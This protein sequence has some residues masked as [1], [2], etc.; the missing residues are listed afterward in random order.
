MPRDKDYYAVL[1]VSQSSTPEQIKDAYRAMVKQHHPDAAIGGAPD[2]EKFRDVMEAFSVLS[3][4]E[5]RTNY[6][7]LRKKQPQHFEAQTEAAFNKDHRPDLRDAAG[8]TPQAAPTPGSY[9]E[10]RL[11]ELKAQRE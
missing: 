1:G 4:R 10:E 8:N 9:A 7:L 6:D 3:V 2:A 11:A 5:S